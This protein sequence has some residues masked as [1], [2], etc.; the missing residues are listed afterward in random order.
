MRSIENELQQL[1][2]VIK[3]GSKIF[4]EL[5]LKK[6][7]KAGVSS[8]A[9]STKVFISAV[10]FEVQFSNFDALTRTLLSLSLTKGNAF[11]S[12]NSI[13]SSLHTTNLSSCLAE[14]QISTNS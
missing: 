10:I 11:S 13:V 4:S 12:N 8:L 9:T 6:K 2:E 7:G 5:D 14:L 1:I 3:Y